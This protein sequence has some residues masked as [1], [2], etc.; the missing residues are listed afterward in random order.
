MEIEVTPVI[1][2]MDALRE[3]FF[4]NGHT[5]FN[6]YSGYNKDNSI[7]STAKDDLQ[8][9]AQAWDELQKALGWHNYKG[10]Y[11]LLVTDSK[12]GTGGGKTVRLALKGEDSSTSGASIAG[13]AQMNGFVSLEQVQQMIKADRQEREIEDLKAQI[14]GLVNAKPE[15]MS[16]FERLL[17]R[18]IEDEGSG[19]EA[20]KGLA[21][22]VRSIG[23]GLKFFLMKQADK[24]TPPPPPRPPRQEKEKAANTEGEEYSG[25]DIL[26]M[27][28]RTEELIPDADPLKVHNA[29]IDLFNEMDAGTKAFMI[30][31]LKS[32]L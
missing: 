19:N 31:K 23:E 17:D 21:D 6:L 2:S 22:G 9:T 11:T 15:K 14:N 3:W 7:R 12:N 20:I 25:D 10:S 5:K 4:S 24:N 1:R 18:A 32:K 13:L 27:F 30:D 26:A 29:V 28:D 16:A 8:D